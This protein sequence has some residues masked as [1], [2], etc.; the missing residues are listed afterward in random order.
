[1]YQLFIN[2]VT[3]LNG[4]WQAH[5]NGWSIVPTLVDALLDIQ[6]CSSIIEALAGASNVCSAVN[7]GLKIIRPSSHS[8]HSGQ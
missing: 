2:G 5:R 1:M 7:L 8:N 3:Y 6:G 4:L